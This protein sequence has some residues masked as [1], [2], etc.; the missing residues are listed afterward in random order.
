METKISLCRAEG[1]N[2]CCGIRVTLSSFEAANVE[3]N[4]MVRLPRSHNNKVDVILSLSTGCVF[5]TT[6]LLDVT[7]TTQDLKAHLVN[8]FGDGID[9]QVLASK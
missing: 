1:P 5:K 2:H 3:L 9:P 7:A 6:Y 8:V 4:N